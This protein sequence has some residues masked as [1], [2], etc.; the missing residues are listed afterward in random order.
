MSNDDTDR[1]EREIFTTEY[2]RISLHDGTRVGVQVGDPPEEETPTLVDARELR[3]ALSGHLGDVGEEPNTLS[4]IDSESGHQ[5]LQMDVQQW[6]DPESVVVENVLTN[7]H[8][9]FWEDDS[10]E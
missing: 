7:P 5:L 2:L 9:D 6:I 4:L 10:D 8:A 1:C 3:D